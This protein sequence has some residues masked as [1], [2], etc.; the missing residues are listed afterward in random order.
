MKINP[1]THNYKTHNPF[2]CYSNDAGHCVVVV[3]LCSP[4]STNNQ[5]DNSRRRGS[6]RTQVPARSIVITAG[7]NLN[8]HHRRWIH[9]S[10]SGWVSCET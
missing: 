5:N 4:A 9:S 1:P 2:V 10:T 8:D 6:E 3:P 7:E